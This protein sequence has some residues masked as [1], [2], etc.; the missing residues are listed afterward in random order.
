MTNILDVLYHRQ[1]VR[2]H[3]IGTS[4]RLESAAHEIKQLHSL[5]LPPGQYRQWRPQQR[6]VEPQRLIRTYKR[7]Q[8]HTQTKP[9]Q[10]NRLQLGHILL[11]RVVDWQLLVALE[12]P[13]GRQQHHHNDIVLPQHFLRV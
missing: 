3:I 11:R 12:A 2:L 8:E 10:Q 13:Q 6:K 9:Q 4:Y 5:D 7:L 1:E